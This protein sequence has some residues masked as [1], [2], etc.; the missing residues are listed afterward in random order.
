MKEFDPFFPIDPQENSMSDEQHDITTPWETYRKL[1]FL[2]CFQ[3]SRSRRNPKF[4]V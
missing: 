2:K 4:R 3:S 1:K